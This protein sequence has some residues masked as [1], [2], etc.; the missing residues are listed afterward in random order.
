MTANTPEA[1]AAWMA[2]AEAVAPRGAEFYKGLVE[3]LKHDDVLHWTHLLDVEVA[4][5]KSLDT[6]GKARLPRVARCQPLSPSFGR[7]GA[8]KH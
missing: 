8:S 5:L 1:F 7:L 4:S 2:A 3:A 6:G